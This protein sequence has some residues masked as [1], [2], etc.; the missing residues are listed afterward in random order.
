MEAEADWWVQEASPSE[1]RGFYGHD[2]SSV[3]HDNMDDRT[4]TRRPT[5][6]VLASLRQPMDDDEDDFSAEEDFATAD[7]DDPVK[8]DSVPTTMNSPQDDDSV[9]LF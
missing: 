5:P 3:P 9:S 8:V 6:A 1:V 2:S 4:K 7:E